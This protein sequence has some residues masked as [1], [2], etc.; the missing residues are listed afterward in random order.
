[1]GRFPAVLARGTRGPLV[2]PEGLWF[3]MVLPEGLWFS[4]FLHKDVLMPGTGVCCW[5]CSA[6]RA[7]VFP[8]GQGR[9]AG[10][11]SPCCCPSRSLCMQ[12]P[13]YN[14]CSSSAPLPGTK[15]PSCCMA[16][17]PAEPAQRGQAGQRWFMDIY[18][19]S[20]HQSCVLGA[21]VCVWG[22]AG[23]TISLSG[24]ATLAAGE[25]T[26]IKCNVAPW[27]RKHGETITTAFHNAILLC[28]SSEFIES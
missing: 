21:D 26:V 24:F 3:S 8:G 6:G 9:D 16:G 2:L 10:P 5:G 20:C 15:L 25:K 19:C 13:S 27:I 12:V 28:H 18:P 7:V 14:S 17:S 4:L 22:R 1:M 23:P 11:C